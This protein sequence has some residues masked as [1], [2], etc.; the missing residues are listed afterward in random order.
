[1][2]TC[3]TS[4][5]LIGLGSFL[6]A[7]MLL[8]VRY[9]RILIQEPVPLFITLDIIALCV[10]IGLAIARLIGYILKEGKQGK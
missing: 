5:L 8:L 7:H 4:V 10:V 1:M 6:L 2:L 9:H 3:I